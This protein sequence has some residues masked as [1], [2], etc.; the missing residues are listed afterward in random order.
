MPPSETTPL[1][2][3]QDYCVLF[4]SETEPS[5]NSTRLSHENVSNERVNVHNNEDIVSK[6]NRIAI[7]CAIW[8]GVFLGAVDSTIMATLTSSIASS[9]GASHQSSWLASAYLL[10][11]SATGALYGK[12]SDLLGRRAAHLT[13]LAFFL[14]GTLGCGVSQSMNHLIFSRFIA[15]CGGGGIMA[16][17]SIIATDLFRLGQRAIIQGMANICFGTGA[18]LGGPLGGWITDIFG[19]RAAFL[20][21]TLVCLFVNYRLPGQVENKAEL[22]RRIDWMGSLALIW[23]WTDARVFGT[24]IGFLIGLGCFLWVEARVLEPTLPLRLLKSGTPLCCAGLN[25][26]SRNTLSIS[27]DYTYID[28]RAFS[29]VFFSI[30]Y[31][32]PLWFEAVKLT[33]TTEAGSHLIPNSIAISVCSLAAGAGIRYTGKYKTVIIISCISVAIGSF[34]VWKKLDTPFHE[35]FDIIPAGGGISAISTATLVAVIAAVPAK[36]MAVS[37]GLTYLFRYTGQVVGVALSGALFQSILAKE[38]QHRIVGP[39]S[40][41]VIQLIRH[42]SSIVKQLPDGLYKRAAIE[43]YQVALRSV[44]G[45]NAAITLVILALSFG[46][47]DFPLDRR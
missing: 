21:V 8:T 47:Q 23:T 22:A 30:L 17:S 15:G 33:T 38:L 27:L 34:L 42:E 40:E 20:T 37:T 32:F 18:A 4:S 14:V 43:S 10:A 25:F 24:F 28:Q 41:E 9:F 39:G 19:W 1:L 13:A 44:F 35:W 46:V 12:L 2:K 11:I 5:A 7:L 3:S 29:M 36:D 16:T 45:F 31:M 6:K 26:F